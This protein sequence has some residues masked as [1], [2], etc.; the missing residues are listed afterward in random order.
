MIREVVMY[1]VVCDTCMTP[2]GAN[3]MSGSSFAV[4]QGTAEEYAYN[5]GFEKIGE[6]HYCPKHYS[7]DDQG[8]PEPVRKKE[9]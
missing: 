8:N 4:D 3:D 9:T 1:E 7:I 5:Q 6:S 2:A